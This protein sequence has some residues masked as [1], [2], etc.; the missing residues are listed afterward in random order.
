MLSRGVRRRGGAVPA[1]TAAAVL[2]ASGAPP[3]SSAAVPQVTLPL[4][5]RMPAL[6]SP[7]APPN[8]TALALA[9]VSFVFTPPPAADGVPFLPLLWL[10]YSA[11]NFPGAV[12]F[13]TPSYV[14]ANN[15]SYA[16]GAHELIAGGGLVLSAYLTGVD[17]SCVSGGPAPLV[18][19]DAEAMLLNYFDE[20]YGSGVWK[21]VAAGSPTGEFWYEVW[22][23]M[24]PVM[25]AAAGDGVRGTAGGGAAGPS[26]LLPFSSAAASV[27]LTAVNAL[28]PAPGALPD[29]NWTGVNFTTGG[30]PS[31]YNNGR[32]IQPAAAAGLAWLF[33]AS[34]AA[35]PAHRDAPAWL[36]AARDCLSALS[37]L[38]FDPYWEVLLPFGAAAAARMAAEAGPAAGPPPA[39]VAAL[40]RWVLQDDATPPEWP[41]RWGWGVFAD[42]WNGVDVAGLVGSV[43]D[44]DGYAF[45]MDTAA[46]VAAAAPIPRYNASFARVVGKWVSNAANAARLFFPEFISPAAQSDADWVAAVTAASGAPPP[47]AYEGLRRWGF[48]ASSA[49][50]TGPY[51]T[52]DAKW[53][54]GSAT[55]LAVYGGA[56]VGLLAAAVAATDAPDVLAV[57]ALATDFRHAPAWPT[58]VVYN[59]RPAA[60]ANV[61]LPIKLLAAVCAGAAAVDVYDAVAQAVVRAAAPCP[62]DVSVPPDAAGVYVVYPSGSPLTYDAVMRRLSAAGRVIDWAAP[63]LPGQTSWRG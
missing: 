7:W 28:R 45:F 36:A 43:T 51:A 33:H 54:W 17:A 46:A 13:G 4:V 8:Y 63:G 44:R 20:S 25:V 55:N 29:F 24:L 26:P 60:A 2:A 32:F 21:D 22:M 16:P 30:T 1:V 5:D 57:D 52:G 42:P 10:D 14:G 38:P 62:P 47:V 34:A 12:T 18:C 41:Y 3:L 23:S 27:W 11:P 61:T 56:Y 58:A 6:P 49:N 9:T 50:I 37:A 39:D 59:P 40:L 53:N 48:N 35:E 19:A 15:G 31:G